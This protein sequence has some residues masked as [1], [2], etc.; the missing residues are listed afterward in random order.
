MPDNKIDPASIKLTTAS[1]TPGQ[2]EIMPDSLN[3][4]V[5]FLEKS[6]NAT[7]DRML[8]FRTRGVPILNTPDMMPVTCKLS[9]T[10]PAFGTIK[11]KVRPVIQRKIKK[12]HGKNTVTS[13]RKRRLVKFNKKSSIKKLR[14]ELSKQA[15]KRV[16][17][18]LFDMIHGCVT[19]N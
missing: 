16:D 10:A 11:F 18:I 14:K 13:K 19:V 2:P 6:A 12:R 15:T 8:G 4:A 5:T 9:H 7:P 1:V 3:R 17:D